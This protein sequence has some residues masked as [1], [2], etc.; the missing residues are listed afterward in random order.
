MIFCAFSCKL[1][2]AVVLTTGFVRG[3]GVIWLDD[4]NCIGTEYS[5][6]DCSTG[7]LRLQNCSHN[8]DAGVRCQG[9]ATPCTQGAIR[10]RGGTTTSGRVEVC[11]NNVWGTVC[12][13]GWSRTDARVA[14]RQ[15]GLPSTS[16]Q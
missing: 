12:D 13:D 6:T 10:L 15:L 14:C 16:E 8:Q 2:G 3:S 1:L 9:I 11:N 5:L 4:V 7:I